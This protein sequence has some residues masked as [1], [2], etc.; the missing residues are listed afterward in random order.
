[1]TTEPTA[2]QLASVERAHWVGVV[3]DGRVEDI[4][5]CPPRLNAILLSDPI[6]LEIEDPATSLVRVGFRYDAATGALTEPTT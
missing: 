4:I 6:F 3:V 5:N 1:M 2:E